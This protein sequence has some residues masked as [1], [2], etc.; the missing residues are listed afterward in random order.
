MTRVLKNKKGTTLVEL[1]VCMVL[2][3]LFTLAAVTLI[4]P[5]AQAYM[6]IQKQT[7]A[8]NLAD[9]LIETIRGEVLYADG[10]IRFANADENAPADGK[11]YIVFEQGSYQD[12]T[13]LEFNLPTGQ[14]EIMDCGYV[15][16]TNRLQKEGGT[17]GEPWVKEPIQ[18]GYLHMRYFGDKTDE[19]TNSKGNPQHTAAD[20][21][22]QAYGYTTAY[23]DGAY[24]GLHISNLHF[25]AHGWEYTLND[26]GEEDK[27]KPPRLTSLTVVLTVAD[28][29]D[30]PLCTQKAMIPLPGKPQ[31]IEKPGTW[32][33]DTTS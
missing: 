25:Y 2:L 13:A 29:D 33:G 19:A 18:P 20:G 5:S 12:G 7:R 21:S 3:S 27:T 11:T 6:D 30:N 32:K 10:Y 24:M 16:V 26:K 14:I 4:Q 28:A 17:Q 1:I 15:P 23:A 9:T 8:Q 22:E 31:L